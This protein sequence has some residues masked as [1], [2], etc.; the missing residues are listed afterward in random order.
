MYQKMKWIVFLS[1]G[2]F[3]SFSFSVFSEI[4]PPKPVIKPMFKRLICDRLGLLCDN[5]DSEK[6]IEALDE[7]QQYK[8]Q[9]EDTAKD[10]EVLLKWKTQGGN[11]WKHIA[12]DIIAVPADWALTDEDIECIISPYLERQK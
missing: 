7:C 11:V 5:K 10:R 12:R 6:Q 2:V 9:D 3:L 1:I 4:P 8:Q